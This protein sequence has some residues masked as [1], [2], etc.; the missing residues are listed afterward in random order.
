MVI[1]FCMVC[2][3]ERVVRVQSSG[4]T[5]DD[6]NPKDV[7]LQRVHP[8]VSRSAIDRTLVEKKL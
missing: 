7:A 4:K 6:R 3:D 1:G 2:L 5:G 8:A